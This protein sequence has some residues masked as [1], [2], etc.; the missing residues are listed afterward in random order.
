MPTEPELTTDA[1]LTVVLGEDSLLL[2]EGIAAILAH[3]GHHIL[4][5]VGD[6]EALVSAARALRPDLVITDVR[7]P[8]T[9]T[10]EGLRAA[11]AL[12]AE[13]ADMGILVLSQYVAAAYLPELISASTGG[14]VGYLLKDRV[15]HVQS[16]LQ[17]VTDV[18]GGA[19]IIDPDVVRQLVGNHGAGGPISQLTGREQE[20]LSLMAQGR[21]N[22]SIATELFVGEA[23]IRKHVGAIFSKL[24]LISEPGSGTDRRVTAVLTYLRE[25][26]D[27]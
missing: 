17:S 12:R 10:D 4:A 19:T 14:G 2:R 3:A 27:P 25:I 15:G 21:T 26:T 7:M 13:F 5:Q 11:A 22:G 1:A 9:H 20:V 6:G 23:A 24:D 8:P 18:A 16:F